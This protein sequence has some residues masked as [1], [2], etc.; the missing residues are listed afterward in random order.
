DIAAPG[1]ALTTTVP[2]GGYGLASGTSLAAPVVSAAAALVIAQGLEP[3]PDA[4]TAQLVRSGQP[5]NDGAGGVIRRLNVGLATET[6]SPYPGFGGGA[7]VAVGNVDAAP[8]EEI[9]TGAG[10]GG[11]PHVRV[12]SAA[13]NPM[14]NG[15]FAYGLRFGGG[16]DVAAGDVLPD[17]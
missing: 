9:V 3:S 11:G 4:V 10:P 1:N 6:A 13:M 14:G 16:V 5:L 15:F 12:Y 17:L 7:S 8:G 2:G